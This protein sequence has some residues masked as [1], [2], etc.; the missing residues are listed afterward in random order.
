MRNPQSQGVAGVYDAEIAA[1]LE[2]ARSYAQARHGAYAWNYFRA[3]MYLPAHPARGAAG[4]FRAVSVTQR[5]LAADLGLKRP[6]SAGDLL[7]GLTGGLY[8]GVQAPLRLLRKGRKGVASTYE[9]V[10]VPIADS[11]RRFGET[12]VAYAGDVSQRRFKATTVGYDGS[13]P[14]V[15]A[16]TNNGVSLDKQRWQN[17]KPQVDGLQ[18]AHTISSIS[19]PT[20]LL[21]PQGGAGEGLTE[22]TAGGGADGGNR[23]AEGYAE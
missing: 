6:Q 21:S 23:W 15:L 18:G 12:T 16:S 13:Q 3:A 5:Q 17:A 11:Q 4:Q 10:G 19:T 20:P 2:R 1:W 22:G 7:A 9:L 14:T 8:G